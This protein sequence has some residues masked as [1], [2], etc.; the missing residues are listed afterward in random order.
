MALIEC[1]NLSFSYDGNIVLEG[2]N[3]ALDKGDYLC[4]VGENG[5]GKSTLIKG[6]LGL[7]PASSGNIFMQKGLESKYIGYLPQ[8]TQVQKDFPANV[9]EIVLS[10]C[11]NRLGFLPFFT[12]K[13]RNIAEENIAKLGIEDLKSA[14][15]RDLSGGQQQRVLLARAL[16]AGKDL[17]LLDEP[18][19]G[20]DPLVSH[21]MYQV[22]SKINCE[23]Q[24]TL[25]M[26]SHD[27]NT[28]IDYANKVLHLKRSQIFFGSTDEYKKTAIAKKFL[29]G[30]SVD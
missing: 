30:G 13:E 25:I 14:C 4:I 26:V 27:I 3:F 17:L 24:T 15:Y 23:M 7:K 28:A 8:Q 6:L 21:E 29:G 20:L 19:A 2:V 9:Y 22:I 18:V 12:K 5:A 16:C 1:K 10:G 11:L